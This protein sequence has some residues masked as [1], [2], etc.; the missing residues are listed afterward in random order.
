MVPRDSYARFAQNP[1][2]EIPEIRICAQSAE[3]IVFNCTAQ[4]ETSY[5]FDVATRRLSPLTRRACCFPNNW[6][7]YFREWHRDA[8]SVNG[9]IVSS[10]KPRRIL[11]VMSKGIRRAIS[12]SLNSTRKTRSRDNSADAL[13]KNI[14]N[15]A[16][17]TSRDPGICEDHRDHCILL[18]F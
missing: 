12:Y 8:E 15:R 14:K 16:W 13:T 2:A 3:N 18:A 4:R 9:R 5:W 17:M 6:T 7:G 11:I 10:Q 1:F